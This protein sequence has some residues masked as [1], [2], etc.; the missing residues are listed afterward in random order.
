[1]LVGG[2][3]WIPEDPFEWAPSDSILPAVGCNN[4]RCDGCGE[5]VRA[6]C[7]VALPRDMSRAQIY[8]AA[9][10]NLPPDAAARLYACRCQAVGIYAPQSLDS[11]WTMRSLDLPWTCAGHP[12]APRP[13]SLDGDR[14]PLDLMLPTTRELLA[15]RLPTAPHA[16]IRDL[17]GFQAVRVMRLVDDRQGR[18][19]DACVAQCLTDPDP[20]VRRGAL[21]F[22]RLVPE[23]SAA[24]QLWLLRARR[25]LWAAP[26]PT[27]PSFTLRHTLRLALDAIERHGGNR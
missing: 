2:S 5:R 16:A 26:D 18:D 9:P 13:L 23:G 15:A 17:A 21:G 7:G 25:K 27:A 8:V 1:M 3:D 24:A 12:P 6:L 11:P 14:I 20:A 4:L 22:C 10:E 19:L